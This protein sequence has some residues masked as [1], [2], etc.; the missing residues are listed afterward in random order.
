[1]KKILLFTAI[2]FAS[3]TL[4]KAQPTFDFEG[5]GNWSGNPFGTPAYDTPN[6]WATLNVLSTSLGGNNPISVFK[7]TD[8]HSGT[9]ACKLKTVRLSS[10]PS[11]WTMQDTIGFMATGSINLAGISF[12][13]DYAQRPTTFNFWAKYIPNGADTASAYI[14]LLKRN[15]TVRDTIGAGYYVIP[16]AVASYT[17]YMVPIIY[18]STHTGVNP[19]TAIIAFSS[20]GENKPKENSELLIDDLSFGLPSGI[21]EINETETVRV[22]PNPAVN[23]VNFSFS[24]GNPR[25]VTVFSVAGQYISTYN[26]T[27]NTLRI[28]TEKLAA[29]AYWFS[30][31]NDSGNI[32]NSGQFTVTH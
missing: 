5:N 8:V 1:M 29:G 17:E 13:Y 26:V 31:K 3:T 10:P 22:F 15:G 18:N 30:V 16:N 32:L 14:L 4:S 19:D 21:N 6:G 7:S 28:N 27:N 2:I 20:S 25:N 24:S 23:E 9:L 12:G 11:G